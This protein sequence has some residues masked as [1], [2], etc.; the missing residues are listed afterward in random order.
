[1]VSA[2]DDSLPTD[3]EVFE[4]EADADEAVVS[5]FNGHD[6]EFRSPRARI[7]AVL[8]RKT[9]GLSLLMGAILQVY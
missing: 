8:D 1:M 7:L 9:C 6:A 4:A 2:K 3:A 5:R